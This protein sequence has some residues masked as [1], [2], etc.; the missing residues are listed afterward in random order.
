[1]L[2][3]IEQELTAR[4]RSGMNEIS[5]QPQHREDNPSVPTATALMSGNS[6]SSQ[7][8]CYCSQ[9]HKPANCEAVVQVVARKQILKRSGRC[10]VCLKKDITEGS[11]D[12]Q[13]GVDSAKAV[14]TQAFVEIQLQA[15]MNT[16]ALPV[17][18]RVLVQCQIHRTPQTLHQH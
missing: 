11:V 6:P 7:L 16:K 4:E 3:A 13:A 5:R 17:R 2:T 15:L 1:M 14:T 18:L 8:C 10:F 9:S 12:H